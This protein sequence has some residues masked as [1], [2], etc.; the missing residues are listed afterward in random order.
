MIDTLDNPGWSLTLACI[1]GAPLP[2]VVGTL[3]GAG[4]RVSENGREVVTFWCPGDLPR[5]LE[6]CVRVL[7]DAPGVRDPLADR[8]SSWFQA[9][10][11]GDWE[12]TFGVR[13]SL[14]SGCWS[15][16]LHSDDDLAP[17]D[18]AALEQLGVTVEV[19]DWQWGYEWFARLSIPSRTWGDLA[20]LLDTLEA[21]PGATAL[22]R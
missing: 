12:H 7:G 13:A 22:E 18:V 10:C 4:R 11:D 20:R 14:A 21:L 3:Q 2:D 19:N 1:D 6:E 16:E 8:L 5:A 9:R 15:F 17:A